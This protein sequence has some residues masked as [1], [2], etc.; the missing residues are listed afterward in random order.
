MT[1]RTPARLFEA[2]PFFKNEAALFAFCGSNNEG[3]MN[4]GQAL[5][6]MFKVVISFFF[7]NLDV[8]RD[9]LCRKSTA[10]EERCNFMPDCI[11]PFGRNWRPFCSFS[12]AQNLKSGIT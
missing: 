2:L 10:F 6:D 3:A 5:P 1:Y 4:A 12:Q 9:I 11:R 7:S 8:R